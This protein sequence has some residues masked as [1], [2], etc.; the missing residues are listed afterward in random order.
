MTTPLRSGFIFSSPSEQHKSKSLVMILQDLSTICSKATRLC[1]SMYN[2]VLKLDRNAYVELLGR[3]ESTHQSLFLL[4]YSYPYI[5]KSAK[6]KAFEGLPIGNQSR[7]VVSLLLNIV[8]AA[9]ACSSMSWSGLS[10]V[11]RAGH[12]Q[13]PTWSLNIHGN[14]PMA[15]LSYESHVY[16]RAV[17]DSLALVGQELVGELRRVGGIDPQV[18]DDKDAKRGVAGTE[19]GPGKGAN[20][21]G[22]S[23]SEGFWGE[24]VRRKV[25][26]IEKQ[27]GNLVKESAKLYN[28]GKD[29]KTYI[30][31]T[32]FEAK[33]KS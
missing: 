28:A 11:S 26:G 2:K 14:L 12:A 15:K 18:K 27:L 10:E 20:G 5:L 21:G 17:T 30:E 7:L 19:N 32:V 23:S 22:C 9:W 29:A 3:I 4:T 31:R 6:Q 24:G 25:D 13:K 8:Q 1:T 33:S 16:F